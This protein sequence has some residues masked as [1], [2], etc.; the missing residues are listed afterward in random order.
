MSGLE[1]TDRLLSLARELLRGTVLPAVPG[2]LRYPTSMI[3]AAMGIAAREL[4]AGQAARASEK[5]ALTSFYPMVKGDLDRLRRH[6][7]SDLRGRSFT[8][9]ERVEL[10]TVLADVVRARLAI[11]QPDRAA[12]SRRKSGM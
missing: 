1:G 2:E 5:E 6:L 9:A 12:P 3:A 11:S 10:H 8:K 4:T 7:C